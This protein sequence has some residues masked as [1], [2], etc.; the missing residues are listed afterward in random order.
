MDRLLASRIVKLAIKWKAGSIAIPKIE[1]I[2]ESVESEV[3]ARAE[4]KFPG[5]KKVQDKYA[6]QFRVSFHQWSYGRLA[7]AIRCRADR[8]GVLIETA[9]QPLSGEL[10]DKAKDLAQNAYYSREANK[11]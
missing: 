7:T 3:R 1:N 11:R 6:K 2:R 10:Q 8:D 4:K 5:L 9:W